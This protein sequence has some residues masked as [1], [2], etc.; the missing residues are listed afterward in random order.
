MDADTG[1]PKVLSQ[2]E[3]MMLALRGIILSA[4]QDR[5]GHATIIGVNIKP[6]LLFSRIATVMINEKISDMKEFAEHVE[7]DI[8]QDL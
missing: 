6:S 7:R 2:D 8:T 4:F 5:F 3:R 1:A